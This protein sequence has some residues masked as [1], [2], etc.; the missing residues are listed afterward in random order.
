VSLKCIA[1][2]GQFCTGS[3]KLSPM[4]QSVSHTFRIKASKVSRI[5]VKLPKRARL[6][7]AAI[8]KANHGTSG[9]RHHRTIHAKLVVSTK[10]TT[11]K[12]R[13]TRGMLNVKL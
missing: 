12:A 3:F 4:G 9:K 1:A 5:A 7:A 11:G 13:I 6:A 8:A 10:Q 2:K